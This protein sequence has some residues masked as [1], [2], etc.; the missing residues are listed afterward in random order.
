MQV[1]P[2]PS[3]KGSRKEHGTSCI[4][5]ALSAPIFC[6][7]PRKS[8]VPCY[9]FSC[10]IFLHFKTRIVNA[11]STRLQKTLEDEQVPV[12][13]LNTSYLACSHTVSCLWR[14]E[15][16]SQPSNLLLSWITTAYSTSQQSVV[17]RST[18]VIALK[19][20]AD[21]SLSE[22]M[23]MVNSPSSRSNSKIKAV[24]LMKTKLSVSLP[25]K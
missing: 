10:F 15:W 23:E 3:S 20:I 24:C 17:I 6:F 11:C 18:S 4:A 21:Q 1:S 7:T 14:E 5:T 12:Q 16:S 19:N 13:C 2:F 9:F 22:V 8:R 25:K